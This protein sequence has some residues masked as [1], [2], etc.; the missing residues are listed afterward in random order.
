MTIEGLDGP[1]QRPA[2]ADRLL[3][4]AD[5]AAP[6][7]K[8]KRTGK[9]GTYL[10]IRATPEFIQLLHVV[11]EQRDISLGGYMR[12]AIAKQMAK[13]LNLPWDEVLSLTPHPPKYG[14]NRPVKAE[15]GKGN[16]GLPDDGTG[17][18][19]WDD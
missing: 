13:D 8:K 12:R 1:G 6:T 18:G 10:A 11:C 4:R 2:W 19:D 14:S 9:W 3:Q 5:D 17:F 7:S 16:I 15:P